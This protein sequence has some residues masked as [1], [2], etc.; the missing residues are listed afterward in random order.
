MVEQENQNNKKTRSIIIKLTW[1]NCSWR[2]FL[3]KKKLKNTGISITES[4]NCQAHGN[5]N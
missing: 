1:Y 5:V 2:I 3:N 4:F